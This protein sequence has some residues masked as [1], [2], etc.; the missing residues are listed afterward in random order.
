[1]NL[2]IAGDLTYEDQRSVSAEL[3]ALLLDSLAS[4][5]GW[6]RTSIV[7][8]GGNSLRF[9]WGSNRFSEDLDF[10]VSAERFEELEAISETVMKIVRRNASVLWNGC[11]L[12]FKAETR[13]SADGKDVLQTWDLRW[14]H[15]NRR[16]KV[17]VKAEF[18][19]TERSILESYASGMHGEFDRVGRVTIHNPF[20]L[21]EL[22]SLWGDKMKA[23][24]TRPAFKW[25]DVYDIAFI[26]RKLDTR[27]VSDCE[28]MNALS[29]SAKVYGKSIHEINGLLISKIDAGYFC[30]HKTFIADMRR[31]FDD[32]SLDTMSDE[33]LT[34]M[35]H[36]A[37]NEVKRC[38]RL[39]SEESERA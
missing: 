25:R 12:R 13:T 34:A 20:I 30:D 33:R 15:S 39:L 19:R 9:R 28:L 17:M 22:S 24:A 26:K 38:I 18:Y 7:L 10:M 37:G 36:E 21:P 11:D 5:R 32:N 1:M 27:D 8:H 14:Y 16:G 23:I 6:N 2:K 4:V 35:L 29:V 3:Q 31:W